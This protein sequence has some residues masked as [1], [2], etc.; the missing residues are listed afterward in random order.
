MAR[1]CL[2]VSRT[3]GQGGENIVGRYGSADALEFKFSNR[4][5][6]N[7]FFDRHQDARADKNL[8]GL[9]FVAQPGCDIGNRPDGGIVETAFKANGAER[10][11]SVRNADAIDATSRSTH[12]LPPAFPMPSAQPEGLGYRPE[13]GH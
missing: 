1:P 9:G 10:G 12:R 2:Q 6:G 4:L 7:G 13:W 8:T 5:D 3:W 11:K